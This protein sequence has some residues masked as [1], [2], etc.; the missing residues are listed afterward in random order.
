MGVMTEEQKISLESGF[1]NLKSRLLTYIRSKIGSWEESEDL[2]QEVF[3]QAVQRLNVFDEI[4]NMAA[5]L[6][7][8]TRNKVVDWYRTKRVE[9]V[10]LSESDDQLD[11]DAW[12]DDEIDPAWDEERRRMVGEAI[13]AAIDELP[14][15]QKWVFVQQVIEGKTFQQLA[16]ESGES[17]NTLLARKRYAVLT[18]RQALKEMKKIIQE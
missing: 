8:L 1:I 10:S 2:L 17:I 12:L 11:L 5:W 4:D 3:L 18:L 9:S 13:L 16:D 7:T 15:K 6:F 14:E